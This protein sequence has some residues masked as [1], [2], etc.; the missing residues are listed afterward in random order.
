MI[1]SLLYIQD[2]LNISIDFVKNLFIILCVFFTNV[3]LT[4]NKMIFNQKNYIK[5]VG[6]IIVAILCSAIK[7]KIDYSLGTVCSILIISIIFS[8][9]NFTNSLVTTIISFIINYLILF[10]SAMIDFIVNLIIQTNND[11]I[12]LILILSVHLV[13]LFRFYKL[14][15]IKYGLSFLQKSS[16]NDYLD[17]LILNISVMILFSII[18]FLNAEQ[19]LIYGFSICLIIFAIIMFISIQK[20]IQLYYKQ[21]LLVKELN[22]AKDELTKKKKEVEELEQENLDFSEKSHSLSHR[23]KSLE[24]K[25]DELMKKAEISE[26]IDLKGRIENISKELYVKPREMELTKTDVSNVDD[27]LKYMQ[28]ECKKNQIDFVLQVN[29]NIHYMVNNLIT[30]EELEILIADHVKDAIIAINHSDNINKSIMVRIGKIDE[31]YGLYVYDSGVEF[32][33]KVLQNLGKKPITTYAT[34]GGKG[35]GFMNTFETLK[36]YKASLIIK[37]IGMPSKENYTKIVMI[38]F[39]EKNEFKVV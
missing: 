18:I 19:N 11:Y 36:R 12:N 2:Y 24:Y 17:I 29:G 38:K 21:K 34:E 27:M 5:I 7:Y 15:R 25:L 10:I 16:D 35:I 26:K 31:I 8:K 28:S 23:Q 13:L 20:S 33:K 30:K 32:E 37:E 4:S 1:N 6:T 3:K 14:K 22:E 39:D 9:D